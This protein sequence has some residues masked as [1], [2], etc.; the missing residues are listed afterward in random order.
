LEEK[1]M[2]RELENLLK[3]SE[4]GANSISGTW[5]GPH[6]W[7]FEEEPILILLDS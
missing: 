4:K 2:L 5:M 1:K 6:V 7:Y 3:I